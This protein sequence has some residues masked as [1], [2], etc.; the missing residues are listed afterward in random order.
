MDNFTKCEKEKI[1]IYFE[2]NNVGLGGLGEHKR[3]VRL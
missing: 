3:I 1:R 2:E